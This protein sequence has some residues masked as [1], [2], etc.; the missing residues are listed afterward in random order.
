LPLIRTTSRVGSSR[1]GSSDRGESASPFSYFFSSLLELVSR[2]HSE[3]TAWSSLGY[4]FDEETGKG[5]QRFELDGLL[6]VDTVLFLVEAKAGAVRLAARRGAPSAME[7]LESLVSD[8]YQQAIRAFRFIKSHSSVQ[9]VL[10]DGTRVNIV[11]EQFTRIILLTTTLDDLSAYVTRLSD[12]VKLGVLPEGPLP[13]AVAIHDLEVMTE[14]VDGMGQ[15]IHYIERRHAT[16]SIQLMASSEIDLFSGYLLNGLRIEGTGDATVLI[17]N[18][19]QAIDDH[20]AHRSG[21]RRA[22]AAKPQWRLAG[23]LLDLV[24]HL[25][26]GK[27]RGFIEAICA[28]LEL[29]P[30]ERT[31]FMHEVGARHRSAARNGFSAFTYIAGNQVFAFASGGELSREII[32]EY[33]RAAKQVTR[34]ERAIGIMQVVGRPDLLEVVIELSPWQEEPQRQAIAQEIMRRY[35]V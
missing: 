4:E 20:Y 27:P 8:A 19:S 3:S 13:W 31:Q 28:L 2:R 15:L 29:G 5:K 30:G 21:L 33:T 35:T 22:H 26:S 12:L 34:R 32:T 10:K 9:F 1:A 18:L 6:I 24:Q 11:S 7:D 23:P 16:S 25:E 17:P 14:L